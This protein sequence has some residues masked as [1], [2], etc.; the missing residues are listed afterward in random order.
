MFPGVLNRV[1]DS[2]ERIL[3]GDEAHAALEQDIKDGRLTWRK[4]VS[5]GR[6]YIGEI[7]VIGEGE[8]P[9]EKLEIHISPD[10]GYKE[11]DPLHFC[12]K[13]KGMSGDLRFLGET[14]G[15]LVQDARGE[16]GQF[17]LIENIL[18][19]WNGRK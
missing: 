9:G 5:L 19:A 12:F 11:G 13:I 15:M 4:D 10:I 14:Y 3:D 18:A 7:P 6:H 1:L 16:A 17:S 2:E 8:H